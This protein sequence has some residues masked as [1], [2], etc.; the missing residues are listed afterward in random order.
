MEKKFA[1]VVFDRRNQVEKLGYGKVDVCVYLCRSE[2]KFI[3]LRNCTPIEW[4]KYQQSKELRIELSVYENIA[5]NMQ[6]CGEEMTIENYNKHL[7]ITPKKED[8]KLKERRKRMSSP[9]GFIDFIKEEMAKEDLQPGTLKRRKVVLEALNR[10]GRLNRFADVTP[11]NIKA[12]DEFLR[13]EDKNRTDVALNNYHKVLKK[14][15][16]AA[17]DRD[18]ITKYPYD[19]PLCKFKRGECKERKPLTEDELL[20]VLK[21]KELSTGEEHAR[22]LF[23]F[24][25]FTGLAYADNQN[26]D[27]EKMTVKKGKTYFIDGERLKNGHSFFTPILPQAME[28]LKKYDYQ[29]PKMSNQKMNQYLHLVESRAKLH[30][31]MTSHVARHSFATIALNHDIPMED[32]AKMLGH[33]NINTTKIYAKLLENFADSVRWQLQKVS[34][35]KEKLSADTLRLLGGVRLWQ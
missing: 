1:S 24:S 15:A 34:A 14:Y 3:T 22:D 16:K 20:V 32:V 17:F 33:T 6:K 13:K 31:P 35:E 25:A 12:F 23:V 19:S 8:D 5:E 9:T 28:I 4:K 29:L 27:F 21:L 30:K 2:R 7:G 18:Y 26:F 11:E 10:F